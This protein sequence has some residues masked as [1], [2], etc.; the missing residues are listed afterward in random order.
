MP[1][2]LHRSGMYWTVVLG[3]LVNN[4]YL[5]VNNTYLL[6]NNTYLLVNNT[7]LL[8]NNTYLLVNNTYLLVNNTYLLVNNTYLL[9]Y[10]LF[11]LLFLLVWFDIIV[12]VRLTGCNQEF[13]GF[14]LQCRD[15]TTNT[16]TGTF[17]LGPEVNGRTLNCAGGQQV[18][19][20]HTNSVFH[21]PL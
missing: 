15:V 5:L 10:W 2:W 4:T 21:I 3:C 11:S 17:T 14:H 6:V 1:L 16:A 12:V 13:K 8:V 9:A 18:N 20:P 7:Y 19:H